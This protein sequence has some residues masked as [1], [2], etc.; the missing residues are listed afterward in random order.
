MSDIRLTANLPVPSPQSPTSD[1]AL[2]GLWLHRRRPNT[3]RAYAADATRLTVFA[4]KPLPMLTLA[5]VQAFAD[6]LGHLAPASQART[7]SAV[8]SLLSFGHR[9]GYLPVNVG[10]ALRLPKGK[11]TLAERIVA[12]EDIQR[13]LAL[14][15]SARN[16]AL[17]RLLYGG[18]LRV[19]E[20]C[21]LRWRDLQPRGEAGQVNVYGK[22]G[23]TRVVL[24]SVATWREVAALRGDSWLL[25]TLLPSPKKRQNKTPG[26]DV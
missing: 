6:S 9:L 24:L 1:E 13:M 17:L 3:Q 16:R 12:E 5:D 21:A 25:P 7:L 4:Q 19:S 18:G 23:T 10:A 14:E 22:G 20:A 26:G 15:P 11:D 8:K 2:I